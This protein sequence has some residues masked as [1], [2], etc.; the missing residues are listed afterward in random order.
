MVKPSLKY[1]RPYFRPKNEHL[2]S[3]RPEKKPVK[4]TL[5]IFRPVINLQFSGRVSIV[6][7][8]DNTVI[9]VVPRDPLLR[10]TP[11]TSNPAIFRGL[12]KRL[13]VL[14]GRV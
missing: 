9:S 13:P 12:I 4:R 3:F 14:L 6:A 5:N 10:H 11:L 1:F 7:S 8:I 2:K